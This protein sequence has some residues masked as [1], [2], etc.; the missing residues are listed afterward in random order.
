M[1][2][3]VIQSVKGTTSIIEVE[4]E[5]MPKYYDYA[6]REGEWKG[7]ITAPTFLYE[8]D[9]N[10]NLVPP[11]WCWWAFH[12]SVEDC[13]KYLQTTFRETI[14]RAREKQARREKTAYEPLSTEELDSRVFELIRGV[15]VIYLPS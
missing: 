2:K 3:F 5:L 9:V 14:V 6:L 4:Y 12:D 1:R 8:K 7:K 15:V 13:M 10:N 11:I